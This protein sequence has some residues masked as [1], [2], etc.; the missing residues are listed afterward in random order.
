MS[1]RTMIQEMA[2]GYDPR[3]VEAYMRVAHST[4]DGLSLSMFRD[5]VAIACRCVDEGGTEM[6][7]R[8]ARSFGF[9][10]EGGR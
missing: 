10:P 3:H 2:P 1:Y 9:A 7:E 5:E 8:I 4:L 6:A